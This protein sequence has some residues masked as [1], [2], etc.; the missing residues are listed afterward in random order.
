MKGTT[1]IEGL[2]TV[3][4]DNVSVGDGRIDVHIPIDV[5]NSHL[6]SVIDECIRDFSKDYPKAKDIAWDVR[7]VFSFG[8][9]AETDNPEFSLFIIVWNDSNGNDVKFYD[10]IPVTFTAEGEKTVKK[11]I[12]DSLGEALFNI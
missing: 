7:V 8:S 3:N 2:G 4:L 6:D 5:I 12:W 10:N 9:F 1:K 11:I